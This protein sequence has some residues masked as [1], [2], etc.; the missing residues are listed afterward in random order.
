M[1]ESRFIRTVTFGGYDKGDVDKRLEYLYSQVYDLKNELRATKLINAKLKDGATEEAAENSVLANERVKLTEFQVKNET[2]SEKLKSTDEDNKKKE[3]EL[4]V[5]REKVKVLEEQLSDANTKLA[6]A[7]SGGDAGMFGVVFAE[8]QK[9]ANMIVATA[10]QKADDLEADSKKLAENMVTDA[11]NKASKIIFDAETRAAQIEADSKNDAAKM[12]AA[13]ENMK[14][15]ML[16]DMN[17]ISLEVAKLKKV[18]TDFE[19]T[20]IGMVDES[21]KLLDDTKAELIVGGVPV[22]KDPQLVDPALPDAP[23]YTETDNTYVT[24]TDEQTKKNNEELDK[25]KAMADSIGGDKPK[26]DKGDTGAIDLASLAK[27]AAA[28]G[29]EKPAEKEE[30]PKSDGGLGDLLKQAKAIK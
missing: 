10:Q 11:N 7:S 12:S 17:K 22:F 5:L 25:L 27:Q 21:I 9:S 28:I 15:T 29:G 30:A 23:E 8:A 3:E 2:L 20:G 1:A 14:A 6:A 18:L 19:T 24:G 13:S 4:V 26:E 16:N